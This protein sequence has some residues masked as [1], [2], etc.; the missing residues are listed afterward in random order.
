M[1]QIRYEYT[2]NTLPVCL[3]E[4]APEPTVAP[5][6]KD[7]SACII[8]GF[9]SGE[10]CRA[11]ITAAER[12]GMGSCGYD[13]SIRVTDRV[14]AI[15]DELAEALFERLKPF[16]GELDCTDEAQIP[17]GVPP[18]TRG[19]WIPVGLNETF[20]ICRYHPGGF[21]RPH[22][23]GGFERSFTEK[24][25][26][27]FMLYLNDDFD[28]GP[29]R[30]YNDRQEAYD[31]GNP[32]YVVYEYKPQAGDLM[33]FNSRMMHDGGEVL[34]GQKYILRSEVMYGTELDMV[35]LLEMQ[36]ELWK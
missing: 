28:G 5:I 19:E 15:S 3:N 18:A 21:F 7:G 11:Y 24:S 13:P 12:L 10:E 25:F 32:D 30:F 27:T 8:R 36:G 23:D 16:V 6:F 26:K 2:D 31:P 33:I 22:L 17:R 35:Q 9:L 20:R 4:P 29:T 1:Q 14:S 34:S